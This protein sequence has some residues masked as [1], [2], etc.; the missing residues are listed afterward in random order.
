MQDKDLYS[1]ILGVGE[2]W[3]VEAVKL[4]LKAGEVTVRLKHSASSEWPCPECGRACSLY[5]HQPKRRWRHLDTC[6]LRTVPEAD[7]PRSNCPEHGVKAVKL[8]WAEPGS[9]FTALFE[10]LATDWLPAAS[11]KAVAERL[12]LSWDEVHAIQERAVNRGLERRKAE[13]VAHIGVDEK[14][15]T[16][17]HHYFTLV[18]DLDRGRVL[19]AG[20]H[21]TTETLD[22]F[23][24]RPAQ[25]RLR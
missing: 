8:P 13:P 21:R 25:D 23:A 9:R 7:P 16:R 5:D 19:F 22:E 11:Q 12:K 2:P 15:F 4:D 17:G 20:E 6:Q 14:S 1:Q 10:H 24:G 3:S 18:N